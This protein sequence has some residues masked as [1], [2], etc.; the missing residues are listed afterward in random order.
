[1]ALYEMIVYPRSTTGKNANRRT[2]A[3]GRTPAV[4]Y[5]NKRSNTTIELDTA[6]L[7]R[8]FQ[9]GG[10]NA[11]LAMTVEGT[12]DSFVAKLQEIQVHPVTDEI[13]HIDL[14][15][16]PLDQLLEVEVSLNITGENRAVRSG[17]AN[18]EVV[19]RT[20][21][22]ECLPMEVPA[23]IDV[24]FSG[25][26]VGDKITVGD[27]TT[28]A[29]RIVTPADEMVLKLATTAFVAEEEEAEEGAEGEEAQQEQGDGD[30]E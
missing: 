16:I 10:Y 30:G 11:L 12:D 9:H 20:V 29:G 17:D 15:D 18:L 4:V 6:E 21:T 28:P 1:M 14:L 27:L 13:L 22:V 19:R 23:A 5:G 8:A 2:R 7:R 26:S 24:D 3:A 25:L